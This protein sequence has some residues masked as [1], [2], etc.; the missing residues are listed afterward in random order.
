MPHRIRERPHFLPGP[1]L[2][3]EPEWSGCGVPACWSTVGPVRRPAAGQDP[4]DHRIPPLSA[5]T[6]I[7]FVQGWATSI[8]PVAQEVTVG[9]TTRLL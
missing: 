5:G 4:A 9:G 8:D 6:G 7:A 2:M 1:P 3:P